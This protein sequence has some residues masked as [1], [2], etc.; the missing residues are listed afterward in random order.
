MLKQRLNN[1]GLRQS[2]CKTPRPTCMNGVLKLEVIIDV[3]KV[4]VEAFNHDL[5]MIR[6][7]MIAKHRL[8]EIMMHFTKSILEVK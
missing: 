3:L 7:V 8:H 5:N 6:Y 2:P 1:K 4:C